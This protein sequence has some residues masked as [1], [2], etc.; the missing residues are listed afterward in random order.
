[1]RERTYLDQ[2]GKSMPPKVTTPIEFSEH[3][4]PKTRKQHLE[5][6]IEWGNIQRSYLVAEKDSLIARM[7]NIDGQLEG[8]RL[9]REHLTNQIG[10]LAESPKRE[11]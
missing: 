4:I 7:R 3:P 1:M 6:Q 8:I 9:E 11:A 10:E 2:T 5:A